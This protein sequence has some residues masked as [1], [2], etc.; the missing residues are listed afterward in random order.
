MYA[1]N[2]TLNCDVSNR[3]KKTDESESAFYAKHDFLLSSSTTMC[4][5]NNKWASF[6]E[7]CGK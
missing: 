3:K 1:T 6:G 7:Y 5:T 2:A 4:F